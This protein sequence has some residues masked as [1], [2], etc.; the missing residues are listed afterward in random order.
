MRAH[1]A[2]KEQPPRN[3]SGQRTDRVRQRWKAGG[4]PPHRRGKR[5]TAGR[6]ALRCRRQRGNHNRTS[7][8]GAPRC[9]PR[10]TPERARGPRRVR[11]PPHR[12]R[13]DDELAGHAGHHRRG[14]PRWTRCS[15][16]PCPPPSASDEPL[17]LPAAPPEPEVLADL[18]A[19]AGRN[20][21]LTS[22]IGMGYYGTITP[23][24]IQRNV[25][26]NPAWYTA[27][28]P[29]QP[30]ISQGRL[31][32]L[33]NFQT[34]VTDLTGLDLANAS[35]LDEAHGG[36]RG[37]DDVPAAVEEP[38]RRV[39]RR[40]RHPPADDRR[41]ADPGRAG[42]HRAGRR[43]RRRP[44][45]IRPCFGVLLSLPGLVGRGCARPSPAGHRPR[46]TTAAALV[47]RRHRP[48]RPACCWRRPA[49]WGAD[50]VVGSA[51]RF[52][53]PMGFGGPHAAFLATRER[54]RP[55][56][57]R[58]PRRRVAPTR[59]GRPALRLAL[60][61]REQHIRREKATSQHLHGPGAAG[62]HRR[63]V[64][65]VA[66]PRRAGPHRRAGPPPDLDPGR[67]AARGRRRELVSDTWFD[68]L[69]VRVPGPGRR[70]RGAR[71]RAAASTCAPSTPT[72]SASASTRPPR[73]RSVAGACRRRSACRHTDVDD[74]RRDRRRRHPGVRA[75]RPTSCSPTRCSTATTAST[76]CCAT[77]AASPTA[78]SPS[79]AR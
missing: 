44:T 13:P 25:L 60:Q 51:Q 24:V 23:P 3:L 77:C 34:M 30:E 36:R 32:A 38:R 50:I 10:P 58:P 72:P 64:R 57:A 39:L 65:R 73:P 7:P 43:R 12:P 33:L 62:Q 37:H 40:R 21:V 35:M 47:G 1:G 4:P 31:E 16:A 59:A 6:E 68:T 28:T 15:T 75:P 19:L 69:T 46:C 20:Q 8:G 9:S 79:T 11:P 67:R 22:L 18:R 52:G 42:R 49:R 70:G 76:R 54:V 53:V 61:T 17:A 27:Y 41:A 74:A 5:R 29:Y 55:L 71:P 48:A 2:P 14:Q 63:H 66:R 56:A 78:T 26:E 45:S